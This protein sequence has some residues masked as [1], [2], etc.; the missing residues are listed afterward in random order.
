MS[1]YD[2]DPVASS[3]PYSTPDPGGGI[4]FDH[5][6]HLLT[7]GAIWLIGTVVVVAIALVLWRLQSPVTY[8]RYF[9]ASVRR[10]RWLLWS[11]TSWSRV[12][13]A[14]GLSTSKRVTLKDMQGKE[15]TR[16]VWTHPRLLGV[17][18]SAHC[19]RI[20]VRT[21]T[22]QTVDPPGK[23]GPSNINPSAPGTGYVV[24]EDGAVMRVRP[25]TGPTPQY[26]PPQHN[27]NHSCETHRAVKNFTSNDQ[28]R[29][30]S[31][32][33]PVPSRGVRAAR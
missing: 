17:S 12:A 3:D 23:R 2:P 24:A 16:T 4:D 14:C 15:T 32:Y 27:T 6:T 33:R 8:E 10:A 31:I 1:P 13:K 28:Q 18:T 22:G 11:V 29:T 25:I 20:T 26:A 19:L 5:V 21:R 30:T 7:V 9:G